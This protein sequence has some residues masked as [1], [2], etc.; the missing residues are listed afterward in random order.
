MHRKLH[1]SV[2]DTRIFR[3]IRPYESR[4]TGRWGAVMG[5]T[6]LADPGDPRNVQSSV[7]LRS[8]DLPPFEPGNFW[9]H[10][11]LMHPDRERW[12]DKHRRGIHHEN[13]NVALIMHQ[14]RLSRGR[15]LDVACGT[16][17][18][19]SVLALAGW[20][21]V[22]CDISDEGIRRARRRSEELKAR[23]RLVQGDACR[24][25]FRGPF[26][27]VVCTFFV[28]RRIAPRLV[29]LLR[30]GG[31]LL[32]Q[33]FTTGQLRY[34]PDFRRDFCLEPGELKRMF[35]LEEILFREEDDGR[36]ATALLIARRPD[37]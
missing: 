28:E 30:P 10:A 26:D 4:K 12:N 21:V 19:A 29:S 14:G 32:F 1:R 37:L 9:Y 23:V 13:P 3:I 8:F 22:G 34:A 17:D 11:I 2:T 7:A 25:P 33:S 35:P 20:D 24:L 18:N 15:A 36:S 16:G 6:I 27:L 5:G 31:T